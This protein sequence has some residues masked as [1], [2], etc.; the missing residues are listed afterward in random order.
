MGIFPF[1]H[2]TFVDEEE[3]EEEEDGEEGGEEATREH[4]QD[5]GIE[6]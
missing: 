5:S 2:I 6:F 1:T 4:R 3:E